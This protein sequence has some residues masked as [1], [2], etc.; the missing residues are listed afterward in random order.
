MRVTLRRRISFRE[1]KTS[2]NK[3]KG[4][5]K[6]RE[7][8]DWHYSVWKSVRLSA[9]QSTRAHQSFIAEL[10]FKSVVIRSLLARHSKNIPNPNL[11]PL[12]PLID[13]TTRVRLIYTFVTFYWNNLDFTAYWNYLRKRIKI[14]LW[15]TL[16]CTTEMII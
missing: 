16:P 6:Y 11:T 3:F 2:S 8:V 10:R 12:R 1:K 14:T 4:S 13:M 9:K 5:A 15:E 7:A